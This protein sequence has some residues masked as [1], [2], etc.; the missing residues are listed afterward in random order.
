MKL[1]WVYTG[2]A[3]TMLCVGLFLS[4]ASVFANMAVLFTVAA[5]LCLA[6]FYHA[7]DQDRYVDPVL[8]GR[9][10]GKVAVDDLKR[11]YDRMKA[12]SREM[13]FEANPV[14]YAKLRAERDALAV[15]IG[16]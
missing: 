12:L 4:E 13:A 10:R 6:L 2:L 9:A 15:K 5:L 1:K 16:L 7:T 8:A 14:S 11:D 3:A